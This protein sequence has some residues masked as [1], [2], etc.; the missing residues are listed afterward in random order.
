MDM[1]TSGL[2]IR[3]LYKSARF[4]YTIT[5]THRWA[6]T[7]LDGLSDDPDTD[8]VTFDL[9]GPGHAQVNIVGANRCNV[10]DPA[11]TVRFWASEEYL[12]DFMEPGTL[13]VLTDRTRSAGGVVMVSPGA[14]TETPVV[15]L[16]ETCDLANNISVRVT[17]TTELATF[18]ETYRS[19][20]Q[21]L[22]ID[23]QGLLRFFSKDILRAVLP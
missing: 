20:Q 15:T 23:Q 6:V 9:R 1:R 22:Q 13:V 2:K 11:D 10:L 3:S 16:K 8:S 17:L 21:A 18:H 14:A 12:A 5:G 7:A 19:I 4:G